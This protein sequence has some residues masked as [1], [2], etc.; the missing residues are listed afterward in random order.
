M[1]AEN[2]LYI[3]YCKYCKGLNLENFKGDL[4]NI[5]IF[6]CADSRF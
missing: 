6:F 2:I 1:F 5:L 3:S 4:L